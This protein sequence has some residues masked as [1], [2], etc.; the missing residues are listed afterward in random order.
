MAV[1]RIDYYSDEEFVFAQQMEAAQE[2]E[3][4]AE[5]EFWQEHDVCPIC[6]DVKKRSDLHRNCGK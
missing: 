5:H 3:A 1:E 2:Q 6:G 4:R